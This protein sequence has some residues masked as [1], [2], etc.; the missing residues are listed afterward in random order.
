MFKVFITNAVVSKGYDNNPALKFSESGES[1]RFRIGKAVYDPNAENNTRWINKTVK[2]FGP[3]CERIKK[4]QLK[5][6][7]RITIDGKVGL[8]VWEDNN[9]NEQ[10]A[11]YITLNDIEYATSGNGEKSEQ[12][13]SATQ[14]G[15]NKGS[16]SQNNQQSGKKAAPEQSENCDGFG[17][18]GGQSFFSD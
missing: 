2:A 4:M 16:T 11:E 10:S 3:Q 6:G 13:S 15:S 5:E 9:G 7:S 14:N 1:V 12:N 8:D 18:F 17:P